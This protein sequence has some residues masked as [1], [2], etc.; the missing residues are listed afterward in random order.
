LP[1]N[2]AIWQAPNYSDME[3]VS[4]NIGGQQKTVLLCATTSVNPINADAKIVK[5][6][7]PASSNPI[8]QDITPLPAANIHYEVFA[9]DH[10]EAAGMEN[11]VFAVTRNVDITDS[12]YNTVSL[13]RITDA[14][15]SNP[16]PVLV[17]TKQNSS[18]F[19]HSYKNEL[20]VSDVDPN[21]IYFAGKDVFGSEDGGQIIQC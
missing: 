15:T 2:F 4:W 19:F 3:V 1:D 18:G 10:S 13:F 8:V 14:N 17:N 11:V 5:I 20:I 21:R 16:S 12:D 6:I 9:I 7:D